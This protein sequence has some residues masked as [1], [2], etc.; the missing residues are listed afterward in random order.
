MSMTPSSDKAGPSKFGQG[1]FIVFEGG[2]GAGKSTQVR[3]LASW[4]A[5]HHV[6]H[7]VTRQPGGTPLGKEFRELV[8]DPVWGEVS[9]RTETL[10]YAADKAQHVDELIK[11]ALARGEIVIS[12]RYVDSALA[13][14]G[15]GRQIAVEEIENIMRWATGDLR[16]DLTVLLDVEPTHGVDAKEVKDRLEGAGA[17]FHDRVRQHF[18]DLAAR[19]TDHYLVIN[20]RDSRESIARAV[21]HRVEE[22]RKNL[23]ELPDSMGS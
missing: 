8:L 7:L 10:L 14:Q 15:A 3:A 12:D 5:E 2:D 1:L 4:L 11:P 9:P 17:D 13:Y 20:A 19:D 6:P 16:P 18:L 22:L 23:S 21:R